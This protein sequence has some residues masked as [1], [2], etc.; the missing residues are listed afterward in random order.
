MRR[1][2]RGGRVVTATDAFDA[3]VL[4]DGESV[5]AVGTGFDADDVIDASGCLVMPGLV[6]N[7]THLS[8]PFG[9]TWS[10]EDYNTG[11]A[12]AAAGGTT[13]IVDFIIQ[14]VG[15]SLKDAREEWQGRANGAA[16]IDYGFHMA[17]TDARPE[18]VAE[19]DECVAEGITS[20]K[21]FMA[22]KGALMVDDEQFIA[23]LEQTG[24][25]GGLV[26]VHCENGDAV[27]RYQK[28]AIQEGNTDPK[29]HAWSRPP[30]VEGEATGRAIRLA[31]WTKRPLFV[32]H[33]TCEDSV[34]E[35]QRARDR[36]LPIYGE[37]CLQYLMLT[38]D[39]LA[40]PG[41][42]GAK[43]V[44]S[45]PLRETR[46][47]E[48]LYKALR[49]GALQGI[50]TDH[51]PFNYKE[52]KELGLGDFTKIPNGLPAIE[53]RL[54][55][56]YDRS[57]R[58]GHMS[59]VDLVRHCSWGPARIFGLDSKGAIAPGF[60]ADI[61]VFDPE[62]KHTISAETHQMD[63]DY[64][65]FEGWEVTGKPRFVLSRGDTVYEDG[66][67]VSEPGRGRFVRRSIFEPSLPNRQPV[68]V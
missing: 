15:G 4:I 66:K 37:T 3:D 36:G 24:K 22:Y 6:D 38:V 5:V 2:I 48:V 7:H 23:V 64:D 43:Y 31:E 16:H 40:R 56:L 42:E 9:G 17:I 60:D 19:M 33:V 29:F 68:T 27:V 46:H 39:E 65:P 10:C 61:V 47:Q 54:T 49:Q 62:V 51:C 35:I 18:V 50:S 1:L 26:M 34:V 14:Y 28:E 20:F 58:N 13:A 57:V 52:Q 41:F 44:C 59:V 21:V 63:V 32:V 12:S 25:S 11:T 45:P 53:H 8:M 67:I 55:L 30:E